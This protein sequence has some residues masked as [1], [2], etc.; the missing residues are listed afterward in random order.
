MHH[1][2]CM[3]SLLNDNE[4][5]EEGGEGEEGEQGEREEGGRFVCL[6]FSL[7]P[8]RMCSYV[9]YVSE[10]EEKKGGLMGGMAFVNFN[11][12]GRVFGRGTAA[13]S[14]FAAVAL[15]AAAREDEDRECA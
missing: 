6:P 7:S 12:F 14:A 10:R 8:P 3:L 15:A 11:Y 2:E 1:C 9:C 5:I 13:A 4:E